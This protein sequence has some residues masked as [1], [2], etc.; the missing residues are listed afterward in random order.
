M[1]LTQILIYTIY[2]TLCDSNVAV[3]RFIRK[4]M[5]NQL[6][7]NIQYVNYRKYRDSIAIVKSTIDSL[8]W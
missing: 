4:A 8:S 5:F 7:E 2:H 6:I 1:I 3:Y